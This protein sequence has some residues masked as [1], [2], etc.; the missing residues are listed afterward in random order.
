ME[1]CHICEEHEESRETACVAGHMVC[2]E[3]YKRM[4]TCPFCRC[5][6]ILTEG[7]SHGKIHGDEVPRLSPEYV[8][9][10]LES[11][12]INSDDTNSLFKREEEW[13]SSST[14]RAC[15]ERVKISEWIYMGAQEGITPLYAMCLEDAM[16]DI[17]PLSMDASCAHIDGKVDIIYEN[18]PKCIKLYLT[19]ITPK[20]KDIWLTKMNER[21]AHLLE[22]LLCGTH[23]RHCVTGDEYHS[24]CACVADEYLVWLV[25]GRANEKSPEKMRAY[26][27]MV[28]RMDIEGDNIFQNECFLEDEDFLFFDDEDIFNKDKEFCVEMWDK[29]GTASVCPC[30]WFMKF[31]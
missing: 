9:R 14:H 6:Y 26:P 18:L 2:T 23:I 27:N 28:S 4:N 22:E 17:R 25:S 13:D 1:M 5:G 21:Y 11:C 24:I 12:D 31:E 29:I 7:C 19:Y 8:P 10:Y 30:D 15:H 3:C 16:N 20:E